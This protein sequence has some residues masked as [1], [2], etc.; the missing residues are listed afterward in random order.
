MFGGQTGNCTFPGGIDN[1]AHCFAAYVT[2]CHDTRL[3]SAHL[4]VR[5]YEATIVVKLI[6]GEHFIVGPDADE[7]KYSLEVKS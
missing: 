5:Y 2:G 7:H 4:L 6:K 1:L 3:G